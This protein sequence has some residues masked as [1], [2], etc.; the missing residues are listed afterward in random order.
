MMTNSA[1]ARNAA[2]LYSRIEVAS[3]VEAASPHQV[4]QMMM[5]GVLARLAAARGHIERR[6]MADKGARI[7]EAID[8]IECLRS[9]L[10]MN[11]GRGLSVN[12][13]R[14]YEYMTRR[15]LEASVHNDSAA[16]HEVERLMAEVKSGWD[17]I[18]DAATSAPPG[19]PNGE[20]PTPASV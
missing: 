8:I 14:L 7:G 19:G 3:G 11:A 4:I 10:D 9:H 2:R 6:E 12:L 20:R 13:E 15:L 16:V 18:A 17:A 1:A 5:G